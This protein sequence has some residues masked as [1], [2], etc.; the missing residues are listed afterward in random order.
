M[1]KCLKF[2]LLI[3]Q[4]VAFAHNALLFLLLLGRVARETDLRGE[5]Q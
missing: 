2:A 5:R 1:I 3:E 4:A